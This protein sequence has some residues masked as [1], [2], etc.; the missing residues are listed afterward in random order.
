MRREGLMARWKYV[1]FQVEVSVRFSQNE[2]H[3][4]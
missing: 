2:V 3:I 4:R 1:K